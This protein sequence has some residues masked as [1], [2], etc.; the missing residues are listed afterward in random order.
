MPTVAS[1]PSPALNAFLRGVERRGAV[2][3][4]LQCGD[5]GAGDAALLAAIAAFRDQAPGHPMAEWPRRFWGLLLAEPAM[6]QRVAVALP[7]DAT[8]RLGDVATGP[9]AALLLRLAAGLSEADAATVLGVAVPTYRLAL[10][11][12]LPHHADGRADPQAWQHLRD[13]VHRRIKNLEPARL[14]RLAEARDRLMRGETPPRVDRAPAGRA[15]EPRRPRWLLPVLWS[16]LLLCVL[17]LAA[18]WWWPNPGLGGGW[19]RGVR[20]EPLPPADPPATTLPADALLVAH[21]DFDLLAD[22]VGTEA[23]AELPF[24]AWLAAVDAGAVAAD[25]P[26]PD[27]TEAPEASST[28]PLPALPADGLPPLESMDEGGGHAV[29]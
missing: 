17:A 20:I 5:T 1:P 7:L 10:R 9:R 19:G 23:A 15:A 13:Q 3:A 27:A 26:A 29:P 24:H 28:A 6:R 4:E 18:S 14:A 16:L 2:L 8:D 25:R 22:P 12:A 21:P 11:R